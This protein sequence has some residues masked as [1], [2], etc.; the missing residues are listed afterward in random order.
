[1]KRRQFIKTMA[2]IVAGTGIAPCALAK[3]V[4]RPTVKEGRIPDQHLKDYLHKMRN[5]DQSH[6]SDIFLNA[7]DFKLLRTSRNR[8]SRLQ[9]VVGYGNFYL[10]SFDEA[11]RVASQYSRVGAFTK[12]EIHFLE[13]LFYRDG[14][15]YGF[16]GEKPLKRLTARVRREKVVKIPYSGN[17]LYRG[18]PLETYKK[19]RKEIGPDM[20]LTSGVRS[21]IKQFMLFINKA[22]KNQGNLSLASRS[23]APPGYSFHGIGDFD[24]GQKGYGIHNFTDRFTETKVFQKLQQK[25]YVNLRYEEN[26]LLGVRFE[27][28][29]IKISSVA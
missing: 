4:T 26:N 11:L 21:V 13:K 10:L 5:F 8:L 23:L 22:Y 17:Y 14:K 1:M 19:I 18:R 6:P 28:W 29:H 25:G 7:S 16:A 15:D 12:D 9:R 3:S 27:P 20:V 2:V 24:V